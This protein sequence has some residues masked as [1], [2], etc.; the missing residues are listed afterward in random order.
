MQ[1]TR[2][3]FSQ[4]WRYMT[5]TLVSG[6]LIAHWC[7]NQRLRVLSPKPRFSVF[8][9]HYVS[10]YTRGS[11]DHY[12]FRFGLFAMG[13]QIRCSNILLLGTS[14]TELGLSAEQLASSLKTRD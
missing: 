6:V 10:T 4:F 2:V 9:R 14:H 13:E 8:G 11:A 7:E 3:R 12:L 1:T 5:L